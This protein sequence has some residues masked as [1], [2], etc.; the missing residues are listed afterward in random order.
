MGRF[1]R[2]SVRLVVVL[3]LAGLLVAGTLVGLGYSAS[4]LAHDVATAQEQPLLDLST[5]AQLPSV[6]Y[7]ADG[8]VL[9]TLRSD[10]Y[11]QPVPL[12]KVAP[13][14]VHAVLD[15][16]DH[17]FYV[18]GGFD[19]ESI[20][21]ALLADVSAGSAVQ[22]GSTIAE[23]L[24][25]NLYLSDAKTIRRKVREAAL[26][27]RLEEKYTKN[28]ILDAYLNVVYLGSGAYGVQAAA[29]TYFDKD[30]ADV[31]LPEAALLAGLLQAPSGDDPLIDPLAARAR[32]SEVLS[33]MVHYGTITAAEA[34]TA[35]ESPLPTV[36]H[37]GPGASYVT[38]GW[39]VQQVVA[40]LLSNP[41]LGATEALRQQELFGGGLKIYTNEIP[42]LQTFAQK[43]AVE[44]VPSSLPNVVAAFAVM[45]PR[46]GN[47]EALVGGPKDT[48]GQFDDA[49]QGLRQPGSGF[50]LFTLVAALEQGYNVNDTILAQSP[51]A[52]EF[53]A[54][55][56]YGSHP[57]NNDP[58]DPD[59]VVSLVSATAESINCAYLRLAHEVTLPKLVAVAKSMGVSDPLSTTE[60]SIVLG[61]NDVHPIEMTAAYAT[62]ADG[63]VYHPPTFV[64]HIVGPTG[65]LVYNGE[66]K[67]RRVF[68]PLVAEEAL[69]AL[70]ATV[71]YGTGTAAALPGVAV[72]GKTGTT[73]LSDDAW[74]N[75]ITPTFAASVWIGDP[76]KR[77]PM[78]IDGQEVYGASFPTQIWRSVA[79][80]A[81]QGTP[82]EPWPTPDYNLM[83]PVKYIIS[84]GLEHDDLYAHGYPPPAAPTTVPSTTGLPFI[85]PATTKAK[86]TSLIGPRVATG[87]VP[88]GKGG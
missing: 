47:V 28:Q 83:P 26:A 14:L 75:G 70:Q 68:S 21:R 76:V 22:G 40:Q 58:G 7:A 17:G 67:G 13:V 2:T 52:I 73:E 85:K 24:V 48:R 56:Y 37:G 57:M 29:K 81:L 5:A 61:T 82:Y 46:T 18:H 80:Y 78:Y 45:D 72:A 71:Q 65:Q 15:T 9:A 12:S 53:P 33:R 60:P 36:L 74:F 49:T 59:G 27:E 25:K 8:Q 54:N 84:P 6:I 63:G 55:T 62:V 66:L 64:N 42:S 11:R 88:A 69:V 32:R 43:E 87:T 10:Q 44:G 39:Y 4:R 30:A 38:K 16:E 51:C 86:T 79:Q 1:A 20:V 35:N 41:A 31:T 50:K 77:Y 34:A 23:E 3:M 19:V